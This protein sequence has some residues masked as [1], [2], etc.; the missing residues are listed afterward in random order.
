MT[1]PYIKQAI[2]ELNQAFEAYKQA[3]DEKLQKVD[4]LLEEK[5]GRIDATLEGLTE[6]INRF[7]L[8][9]QRPEISPP[10]AHK[11]FEKK[12]FL[13]YILYG[14]E[15]VMPS[16][17]HKRF[18]RT[19]EDGGVFLPESLVSAVFHSLDSLCPV[20]SCATVVQTNRHQYDLI[21]DDGKNTTHWG[22]ELSVEQKQ[23]GTQT[24][25]LERITYPIFTLFDSPRIAS[26]LLED[27]LFNI[28]EWLMALI[29]K[30]MARKENWAFIHGGGKKEPQGI[31]CSDIATSR[32]EEHG[33]MHALSTKVKGKFPQNNPEEIL[34]EL[35]YALRPEYLNGAKWMMPRSVMSEIRKMKTSQGHYLWNPTLAS[36]SGETHLLGYPIVICD[37]LPE[38]KAETKSVSLLFGNFKEGYLIVD[39]LGMTAMRDPYTSKPDIDLLVRRRLGGGWKDFK[40]IKGILFSD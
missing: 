7:G 18:G 29:T 8:S 30:N 10:S 6:K 38:L 4:P 39:R 5:I 16:L 19:P 32:N 37:D 34:M 27:S 24:S 3:N 23:S 20:R 15:V 14:K 22:E 36:E 21:V 35:I 25:K 17:E 13:D 33:K 26:S 11:D 12:S 9:S 2:E 28:E 40:A 1:H 31:L